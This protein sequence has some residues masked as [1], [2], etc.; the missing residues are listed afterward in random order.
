[1]PRRFHA[2]PVERPGSETYASLEL[3]NTQLLATLL[4]SRPT[5]EVKMSIS[6]N[7]DAGQQAADNFRQ[8]TKNE[9]SKVESETGHELKK[10]ADRFDERAESS[11]G[12]S[13]GEKQSG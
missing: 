7:P 6:K 5:R 4:R 10:G 3:W 8:Q 2:V 13:A 12:K 9:E 11:D 1:M